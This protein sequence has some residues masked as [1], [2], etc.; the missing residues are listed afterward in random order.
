[1]NLSARIGLSP[2]SSGFLQAGK[3]IFHIVAISFVIFLLVRAVPGDITDY[4]AARGDYDAQ[5]L[6]A[7]RQSLGLNDSL[8]TQ[9]GHW[10]Q[11]ALHGDLGK[12][13]RYDTPVADMLAHALPATLKLAGASLL[14]GLALGVTL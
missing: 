14:F 6:A 12:S 2:L 10:V 3:Q 5:S 9:F 7:M 11:A 8:A 4:Y 1:M 13:M